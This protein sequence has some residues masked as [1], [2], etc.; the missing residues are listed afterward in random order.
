MNVFANSI[1]LPVF[2]AGLVACSSTVTGS[3][4]YPDASV[5]E[6]PDTHVLD[7]GE[8]GVTAPSDVADVAGDRPVDAGSRRLHIEHFADM[9]S[10]DVPADIFYISPFMYVLCTRIDNWRGSNRLFSFDPSDTA[11]PVRASERHV[12]FDPTGRRLLNV[13]S[14]LMGDWGVVTANDGFYFLNVA[15]AQNVFVTFPSPYNTGG[16][17]V[18]TGGALYV[19]TANLVGT[20]HYGLG[21]VLKY[22]PQPTEDGA[23][24]SGAGL[25]D[26]ISTSQIHPTGMV[27]LNDGTVAVLNSGPSNH[28]PGEP[29][30]DL[31][32]G[33][34][35]IRT[36]HMSG[37]YVASSSGHLSVTSRGEVVTA[38]SDGS[39]QVRMINPATG[40]IRRGTVEGRNITS[41]NI[42]D[43]GEIY[44]TAAEGALT[45]VLDPDSP[46]LRDQIVTRLGVQPA[47]PAIFFGGWLYQTYPRGVL[48]ATLE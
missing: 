24:F 37:N 2:F 30:L 47:G 3:H 19:S 36:I 38:S 9:P 33:T 10:C 27:S 28:P 11:R 6:V 4:G 1:R 15:S 13:F 35:R 22:A 20:T 26:V 21:T 45:V 17:A 34:G 44:F 8:G 25:P 5:R 39:L 42:G 14:P 23:G 41:I 29:T 46:S 32:S 18:F 12:F 16:G 43:E 48:R 40:E 7:A 31:F